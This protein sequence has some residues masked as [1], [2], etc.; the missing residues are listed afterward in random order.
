MPIRN[1]QSPAG[2]VDTVK[3]IGQILVGTGGAT[4]RGF[5]SRFGLRARKLED[6]S[7]VRIQGHFGVLLLTLG[8]TGY[9]SAFLDTEGGVWDR[10]GRE[11]H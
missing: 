7:T 9:Q 1:W 5:R 8:K 11:C 2:A 6:N 3:G 10:S 4:L